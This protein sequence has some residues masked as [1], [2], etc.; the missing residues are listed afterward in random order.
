MRAYTVRLKRVALTFND[1][2][3]L[4]CLT[5]EG[6][7]ALLRAMAPPIA[8]SSSKNGGGDHQP[9][10]AS[11]RQHGAAPAPLKNRPSTY[12]SRWLSSAQI[13]GPRRA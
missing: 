9:L 2:Q 11:K 5:G 1:T 8:V 3:T 13:A 12:L 6:G 4:G 10:K 7:V